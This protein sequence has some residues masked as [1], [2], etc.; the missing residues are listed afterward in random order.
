MRKGKIRFTALITSIILIAA[1]ALHSGSRAIKDNY[2]LGLDLYIGAS[3]VACQSENFARSIG[4]LLK[5][6]E[7]PNVDPATINAW[8]FEHALVDIRYFNI[9]I[10]DDVRSDYCKR[11]D[12]IYKQIVNSRENKKLAKLF[13]NEEKRGK[14]AGFQSQLELVRDVLTDFRESFEEIPKWKR[15]FVPWKNV[16]EDLSEKLKIPEQM[17]I[18]D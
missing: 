8:P 4:Y 15:Y 9:P 11:T 16:R 1:F 18:F 3:T 2:Q 5:E 14:L 10:L 6:F 7:Q 13:K 12:A 17:Y